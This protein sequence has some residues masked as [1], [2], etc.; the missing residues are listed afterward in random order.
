MN[1]FD[2]MDKCVYPSVIPYNYLVTMREKGKLNICLQEEICIYLNQ[3]S[4]T[5]IYL[6]N[7]WYNLKYLTG[8]Y[9]LFYKVILVLGTHGMASRCKYHY[10]VDGPH[11]IDT[12]LEIYAH[13]LKIIDIQIGIMGSLVRLSSVPKVQDTISLKLHRV[14]KIF[15]AILYNEE[16]NLNH[17]SNGFPIKFEFMFYLG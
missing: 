3:L 2:K 17:F 1:Y 6:G 12:N 10:L 16:K 5:R 4:K 13:L 14:I 7:Y 15:D 9:R 8:V 11:T